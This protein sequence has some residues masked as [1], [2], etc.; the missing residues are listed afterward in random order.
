MKRLLSRPEPVRVKVSSMKM[1]R[2]RSKVERHWLEKR[3]NAIS[4]TER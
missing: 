2:E 4:V 3:E 1:P